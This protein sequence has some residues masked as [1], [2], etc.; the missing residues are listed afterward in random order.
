M[1][2]IAPTKAQ[3]QLMLAEK[4]SDILKMNPRAISKDTHSPSEFINMGI[5]IE[6]AQ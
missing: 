3:V 4:D 2:R 5:D 6:F 1:Q